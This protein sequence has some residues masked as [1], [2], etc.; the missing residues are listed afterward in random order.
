LFGM[1]WWSNYHIGHTN[2]IR[3]VDCH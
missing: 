1:D 3:M 2:C